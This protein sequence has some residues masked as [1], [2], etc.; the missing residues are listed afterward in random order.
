MSWRNSRYHR[1][2]CP[3]VR[4]VR[5]RSARTADGESVVG[6]LLNGGRPGE[7]DRH[8]PCHSLY[9]PV[10]PY[11]AGRL[12]GQS[13]CRAASVPSSG[14]R[15][16]HTTLYR[17]APAFSVSVCGD[18][19]GVGSVWMP[20]RGR[21][22]WHPAPH[23]SPDRTCSLSSPAA[24]ARPTWAPSRTTGTALRARAMPFVQAVAPHEH[25]PSRSS[26]PLFRG[27]SRPCEHGKRGA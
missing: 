11:S 19:S 24:P 14:G 17:R 15:V 18:P 12:D 10:S 5:D 7:I 23:A 27:R 20:F 3:T 6:R 26:S 8:I 1:V 16:W 4:C 22:R 2:R 25:D 21:R 13:G 9:S